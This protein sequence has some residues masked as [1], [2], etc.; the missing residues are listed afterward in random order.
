MNCSGRTNCI[1]CTS[2]TPT[3]GRIAAISPYF[4]ARSTR[5]RRRCKSAA[6]E[7]SGT[8]ASSWRSS[9]LKTESRT[10]RAMGQ[11]TVHHAAR[12]AN[13]TVEILPRDV[14]SMKRPGVS[15][16]KRPEVEQSAHR[17]HSDRPHPSDFKPS[18]SIHLRRMQRIS[19]LPRQPPGQFTTP[20]DGGCQPKLPMRYM[21]AP[22]SRA[23]A[24]M[25]G[26]LTVP[27]T[28]P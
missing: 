25:S 19:R 20:P 12:C 8:E 3:C 14:S 28:R 21:H 15:F 17:D 11:A 9:P 22:L 5:N 2:C 24:V 13:E 26:L 18:R 4:R 7:P 6:Q 27:F 23:P 16:R 10:S 1:G